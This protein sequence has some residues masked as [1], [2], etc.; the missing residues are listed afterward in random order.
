MSVHTGA[1]GPAWT[2]L[3]CVRCRGLAPVA[4]VDEQTIG[5]L[6]PEKMAAILK[7]LE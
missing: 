7:G 5:K 1:A 3:R 2:G 4:V 6:A